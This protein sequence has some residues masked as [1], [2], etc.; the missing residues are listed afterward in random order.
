MTPESKYL[1]DKI[2]DERSIV[3]E[4]LVSGSAVDYAEYRRLVGVIQGLT[5]ARSII[6]DLAERMEKEDS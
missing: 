4:G 3:T 1:L 5:L 2:D 6:K